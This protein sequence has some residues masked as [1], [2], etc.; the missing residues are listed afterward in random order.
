MQD[1]NDYSARITALGAWDPEDRRVVAKFD[2]V[3]LKGDM[4][5]FDALVASLEAGA[6]ESAGAGLLQAATLGYAV[7]RLGLP[8][9]MLAAALV[10]HQ[11]MRELG[12]SAS[13]VLAMLPKDGPFRT[14]EA[15]R[16]AFG[17]AQR[18]GDP[19]QVGA[20]QERLRASRHLWAGA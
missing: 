9:E 15:F 12:Q 2:A 13:D 14:V 6:A 10:G 1:T 20:V 11:R 5:N 19:E 16:A 7:D 4:L 18:S 8:L 3:F 17:A